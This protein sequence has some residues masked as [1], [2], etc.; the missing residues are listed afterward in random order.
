MFMLKPNTLAMLT[1]LKCAS[2]SAVHVK[3]YVDDFTRL[4]TTSHNLIGM[5]IPDALLRVMLVMGA[6][7]KLCK[8]LIKNQAV[9]TLDQ[10]KSQLLVTT[11]PMAQNL[12]LTS[13][14]HDSSDLM[15]LD[16]AFTYNC[17]NNHSC[18]CSLGQLSAEERLRRQREGLCVYCS[19][20]DH[21][22]ANCQAIKAKE[23]ARD[24]NCNCNS[25][26]RAAHFNNAEEAAP[27]GQGNE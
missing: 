10:T 11:G 16:A 8:A 23:A 25:N 15:E 1:T 20:P 14:P 27:G 19:K 12:Q 9:R 22:K 5:P 26:N 4:V 18:N 3:K 6:P 7:L 17:D 13:A 2:A 21:E 24:N